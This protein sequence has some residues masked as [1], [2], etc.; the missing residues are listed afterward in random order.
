M[1]MASCSV[2][3]RNKGMRGPK[4]SSRKHL[5]DELVEEGHS[6]GDERTKVSSQKHL[7]DELH[8]AGHSYRNERRN[9]TPYELVQTEEL[10]E[11]RTGHSSTLKK[12]KTSRNTVQRMQKQAGEG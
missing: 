8:E 10:T 5:R 3:K 4:V 6:H 12:V 2:E 9:V 1:M 7:K 11:T